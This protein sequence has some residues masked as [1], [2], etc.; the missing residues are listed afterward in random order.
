MSAMRRRRR[1]KF[2]QMRL[3]ET[4]DS[5][6]DKPTAF[7]SEAV[8]S[9]SLARNR[10]LCASCRNGRPHFGNGERNR[11]HP[12]HRSRDWR[13]HPSRHIR[14]IQMASKC[15]TNFKSSAGSHG[16][17]RWQ[18]SHLPL[19]LWRVPRV[20][21]KSHGW[22]GCWLCWQQVSWSQLFTSCMRNRR[23]ICSARSPSLVDRVSSGTFGGSA[24][25]RPQQRRDAGCRRTTTC[26]VSTFFSS[27]SM[28][29]CVS[30]HRDFTLSFGHLHDAHV[31]ERSVRAC[32][33]A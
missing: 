16:A 27:R 30:S 23:Q 19:C 25:K 14:P 33:I 5:S 28:F 10:S 20:M 24:I 13:L 26:S 12:A 1:E 4:R 22:R 21:S 17:S 2:S 11:Q 7:R 6:R 9:T 29:H 8:V 15:W 31:N 3:S 32:T 18:Y